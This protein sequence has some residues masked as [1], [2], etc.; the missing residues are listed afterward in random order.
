MSIW[1]HRA[2]CCDTNKLAVISFAW[3]LFVEQIRVAY[4]ITLEDQG[5][6]SR[7]SHKLS[8]TARGHEGCFQDM[9]ALQCKATPLWKKTMAR[10]EARPT[11]S[12]LLSWWSV[13]RSE[14]SGSHVPINIS[15]FEYL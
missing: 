5:I 12:V 14:N 10:R 3:F 15:K 11:L 13:Q 9:P 7:A 8:L 2:K 4:R 1:I 6:P